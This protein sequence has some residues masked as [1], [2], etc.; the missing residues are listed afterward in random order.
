MAI[1][2][3]LVDESLKRVNLLLE[4]VSWVKTFDNATKTQILDLIRQDQLFERGVDKND[5]VIGYYSRTTESLS[6]GRKRFNSHYTLFD[7]GDFFKSMYIRVMTDAIEISANSESFR[8]MQAKEWYRNSILGLTDE[9]F[10]VLKDVVRQSYI[11]Y[12]REVLQLN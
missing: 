5:V 4:S 12:A 2:K 6:G 3:T 1:G 9:N 7:T 10:E 8:K 11:D